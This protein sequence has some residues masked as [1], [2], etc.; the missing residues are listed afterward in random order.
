MV[1]DGLGHGPLA[2]ADY[3]ATT[4][5]HLAPFA[6]KLLMPRGIRAMNEWSFNGANPA[7]SQ[8]WGR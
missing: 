4:L 7:C 3:Q 5:K 8:W 1:C 6:P 2:A